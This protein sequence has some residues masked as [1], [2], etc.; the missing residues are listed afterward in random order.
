MSPHP[1][2]KILENCLCRAG[3][4]Q[5]IH[6]QRILD[7]WEPM[8]GK[9]IAEM[10]EPIRVR[11]RVLQVKVINSVWM[12]E[13]QFRK[14]LIIQKLNE[15][16][17]DPG[18]QDLWFFI[19]EKG[20]GKAVPSEGGKNKRERQARDLSR[21][22]KDR[23]EREVSHLDD[24]EMREILWRVFSKGLTCDKRRIIK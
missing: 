10:T 1:L 13:L 17:G 16:A 22:E 14:K 15:W 9:A 6:E 18:V 19:G 20:S 4:Q 2:G 3:L 7:A 11:N 8:V 12:H 23:I 5:R 21:E 24:P